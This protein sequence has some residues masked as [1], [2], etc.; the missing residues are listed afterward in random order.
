MNIIYIVLTL[1]VL[2]RSVSFVR[3]MAKSS[4]YLCAV[5]AS[6]IILVALFLSV[7]YFIKI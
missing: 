2:I 6:V 4:N 3:Y 1:V 5:L 7:V